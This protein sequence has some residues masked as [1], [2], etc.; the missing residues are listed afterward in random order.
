MPRRRPDESMSLLND[1]FARPLDPGYEEAAARRPAEATD[2]ASRTR[3][4]LFSHFSFSLVLGMLALGLLLTIAALQVRDEASVASVER[5]S[6]IS[7]VRTEESRVDALH[8]DVAELEADI[9][10]L[11]R[12]RL[13]SSTAGQGVSAALDRA[14]TVAGAMPVTGPGVVVTLE[15]AKVETPESTD[16]VLAID[17]QQVVNGLWLGGAEGIA[18]NGHRL[19]PMTSIRQVDL[20]PQV[21]YR[22]VSSP[23]TIEAIGD[24]SSLT[25]QL[26]DGAAADWLR[27]MAT[28]GP[29]Y[30]VGVD[31]S[32]QLPSASSSL[33]HAQP[34]P[35]EDVE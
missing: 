22:P 28:Q 26:S 29:T 10:E 30:D 20:V 18:V 19:T 8:N 23:Y 27:T 12:A 16:K 4:A 17:I 33:E 31:D 2:E 1:L 9:A 7:R 11:E 15:D 32:L 34:Q 25:E 5:E 35:Q 24:S 21:N 3:R 14:Q 6:L 13:Q